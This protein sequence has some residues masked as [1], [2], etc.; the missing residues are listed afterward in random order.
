MRKTYDLRRKTMPGQSQRST[1]TSAQCPR[2]KS[3]VPPS[4]QKAAAPV[5][6]SRQQS[7]DKT[8]MEPTLS[9]V[10]KKL[11]DFS[12]KVCAKLDDIHAD[13]SSMKKK[14]IDLEAAVED[15]SARVLDLEKGR[16][17]LL[18]EK[19][20]KEIESLKEKLV[21][22]EI[23]QRKSN[24]LFYGLEKKSEENVENV[25][26]E[27]F[28]CLGLSDEEA[29]S[30]ALVNAHRLPRRNDANKAPQ[31]IIA[32]FVYM[33][34]RNRVL[35]AFEKRPRHPVPAQPGIVQPRPLRISVR[36]DLPPALKAERGN[37]AAVAYKLRKEQNLSTK[38]VVVGTRVLLFSKAKSATEWQ[39]YKE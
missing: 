4:T 18:E 31:P 27:A 19:L 5:P 29:Q 20:Q 17:P 28:V 34:Q 21:L 30:V 7:G 14:M 33:S 6:P 22:S 16:L 35:S 39:P 26:R 23:Y 8:D 36:T 13:I 32:K 3:P 2:P 24:L 10:Q 38:I 37:L 11:V 25:L 12:S 9:D 15:N 1:S